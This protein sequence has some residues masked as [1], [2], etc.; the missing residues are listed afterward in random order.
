M[1]PRLASTAR[2]ASLKG[3]VSVHQQGLLMTP[4][5]ND[6]GYSGRQ[7]YDEQPDAS[8]SGYSMH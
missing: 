1:Y 4:N 2:A 7:G 6:R 5:K 8:G 3:S